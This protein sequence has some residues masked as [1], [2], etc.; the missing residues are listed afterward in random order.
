[1]SNKLIN[2]PEHLLKCDELGSQLMHAWD[3]YPSNA[4]KREIKCIFHV[5]FLFINIHPSYYFVVNWTSKAVANHDQH[6]K[7]TTMSISLDER[8]LHDDFI[9]DIL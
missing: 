2:S 4:K 9:R 7:W 5:P 6:A 3:R 1:M 8:L